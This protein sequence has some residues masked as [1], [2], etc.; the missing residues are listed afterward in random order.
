MKLHH[1]KYRFYCDRV[2]YLDHIIYPGRLGMVASK[3][4]VMMSI[5][6]PRDVSRLHAFIGLCNYYCKFVKTFSAIVK[7]LTMWTRNDQPWIWEYEQE[8]VV[9]QLK[10][11]LT[12]APILRRPITRKTYQLHTDW[13]ALGIG[14]VL[15]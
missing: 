9:Q 10:E 3:V 2:E 5:P 7:P 12:L 11:R 1:G 14:V 8:A 6:R 15:I 4:E 13:S